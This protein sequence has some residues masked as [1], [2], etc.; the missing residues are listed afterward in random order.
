ML[1]TPEAPATDVAPA[2]H[3]LLGEIIDYAGLFPP[4]GLPLGE[5]L[6]NFARYRREPEAWMLARFVL[7]VRRLP[8]VAAFAELLA[9]GP[10]FRF[11]VLGTGGATPGAF[12][13]AFAADCAAIEAFHAGHA[14]RAVADVMEVRLPDALLGA[15]EAAVRRFLTGVAEAAGDLALSLFFEV[16]IDDRVRETAPPVLAALA[17]HNRDAAH[18]AGFKMRTGGLEPAAFPAPD[19]LAFALTACRDA[20]VHFKATAGLHHPVRAYHASVDAKMYG[21]FNVFGAAVLAAAHGLDAD[22]V[23]RILLDEDAASFHFENGSFAWHDLSLPVEAV[24]RLRRGFA[25]SFGSCSFDEPREDLQAL[26][27]LSGLNVER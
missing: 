5:A 25:V 17:A 10:P 1:P 21:F 12:L 22:A 8:E 2:L 26:G 24:R 15:G 6:P 27:L 20:D 16:P 23:R 11:S 3:A 18:P 4:A 13:D 7:P 9:E 14:G 19:A